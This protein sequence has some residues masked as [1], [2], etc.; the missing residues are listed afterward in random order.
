MD[1]RSVAVKLCHWLIWL[2]R[3]VTFRGDLW[4]GFWIGWLDLL[5]TR[6]YRQYSAIA[7]LYTLQFTVTHSLGFSF[8]TSRILATALSYSHCNLT[9]T[10][11]LLGRIWFLS[12]HFFS[13]TL[14]FHLQNSAQFHSF[15]TT[16]LYSL[17]P[18]ST[19]TVL[20]AVYRQSICLGDRPLRLTTRVLFSNWTLAIIV[21]M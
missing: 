14:D 8:F 1:R 15:S 12:C 21:L 20:P 2:E 4:D 11:I 5:T 19:W 16:V 9:H 13:I 3:V 17:Y 6:D 7:Y 18:A 10:W